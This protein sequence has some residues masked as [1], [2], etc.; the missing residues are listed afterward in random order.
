MI[1]VLPLLNIKSEAGTEVPC[2]RGE[3]RRE[4]DSNPRYGYPYT[5]FPSERLKPLGH[6][7]AKTRADYS[8]GRR[9]DKRSPVEIAR[10]RANPAA[11]C[12]PSAR[13]LVLG[14]D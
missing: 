3:W 2:L 7:S 4:W 5:R 6:P 1:L 9:R 12:A 8:A 10:L 11:G 13:G 14:P